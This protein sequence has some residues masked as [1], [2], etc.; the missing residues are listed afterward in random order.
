MRTIEAY[1]SPPDLMTGIEEVTISPDWK[2]D[3]QV[4]VRQS[5]PLP[6]TIL[7]LVLG[8]ATGG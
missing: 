8:V 7:S 4:C 2:Q 1:G 3:A 6:A 5:A